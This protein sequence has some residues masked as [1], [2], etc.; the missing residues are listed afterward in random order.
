[1][2][3]K[4]AALARPL[5]LYAAGHAALLVGAWAMSATGSMLPMALASSACLMLTA[6]LVRHFLSPAEER[7]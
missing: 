5:K 7:R 2:S 1:M 4:R 3:N 6:P